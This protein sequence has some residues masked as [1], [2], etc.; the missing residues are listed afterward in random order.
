MSLDGTKI[1]ANASKHEAMRY[2][3][4]KK[5]EPVLAKTVEDWMSQASGADDD[6]SHGPDRRGD[7]AADWMA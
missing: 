3:R 7:E 2:G 6:R 4:M 1:K 5:V